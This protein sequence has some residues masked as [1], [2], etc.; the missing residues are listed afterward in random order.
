[1][2]IFFLLLL[3]NTVSYGDTQAKRTNRTQKCL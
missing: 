1:M 2:F 3:Y